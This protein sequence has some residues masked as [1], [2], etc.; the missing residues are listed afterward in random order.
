MTTDSIA[1]WPDLRNG[2]GLGWAWPFSSLDRHRT[3]YA[4]GLTPASTA[5]QRALVSRMGQAVGAPA[6]SNP[7]VGVG[8]LPSGSTFQ[9]V[10]A[11]SSVA[12][13][14]GAVKKFG[15]SFGRGI[16]LDSMDTCT[17]DKP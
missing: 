2:R 8:T 6:E 11:G 3:V 16:S 13:V 1:A 14:H 5:A 15:S 10:G 4:P 17:F 9:L 12:A 7:W